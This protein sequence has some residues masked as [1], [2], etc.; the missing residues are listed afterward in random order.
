MSFLNGLHPKR[1][2]LASM[3]WVLDRPDIGIHLLPMVWGIQYRY[4]DDA[5][6]AVFA[7]RRY[8]P[9]DYIRDYEDYTR[10]F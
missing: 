4:S 1:H 9:D 6:L 8:Y 2:F 3:E 7:P 10:H 5:L